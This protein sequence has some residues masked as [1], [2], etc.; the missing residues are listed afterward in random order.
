MGGGMGKRNALKSGC[1][2]SLP[3]SGEPS[4]DA[5][6]RWRVQGLGVYVDGSAPAFRSKS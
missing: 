6:T 5:L 4:K 3:V 2:S 1:S